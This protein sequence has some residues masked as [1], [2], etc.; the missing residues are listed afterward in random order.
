MEAKTLSPDFFTNK[1]PLYPILNIPYSFSIAPGGTGSLGTL[2]ALKQKLA[3]WQ[4]CGLT[5]FQLRAKSI[6]ALEYLRL[7]EKLQAAYP[8]MQILA[9]DFAKAAL[10]EPQLFCGLHL[11]QEDLRELKNSDKKTRDALYNLSHETKTK[12]KT[13]ILGLSTHGAAQ[14]QKALTRED[15]IAWDYIA[16]GPCFATSSKTQGSLD[17]PSRA[18]AVSPPPSNSPSPPLSLPEFAEALEIFL[19][20]LLEPLPSFKQKNSGTKQGLQTLV[21]IGGIRAQ[22]IAELFQRPGITKITQS[23]RIM[24]AVIQAAEDKQEIMQILKFGRQ[25]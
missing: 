7:A 5:Y 21:L 16:L 2:D 11:G 6:S 17:R 15:A 20:V 10:S 19:E 23:F 24:P 13:F 22:N 14:I 9:N 18:S 4:S 8:Q 3:M 1:A 12:S 25:I